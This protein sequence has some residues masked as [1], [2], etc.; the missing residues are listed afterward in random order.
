MSL[1]SGFKSFMQGASGS[2]SLKD[3]QYARSMQQKNIQLAEEQAQ[4]ERNLDAVYKM[5]GLATDLGVA[6]NAGAGIDV[7]KLTKLWTDQVAS[8]EIDP[9]LS[10]LAA[11]LGNED[12]A[13]QTNPGF[14]FKGTQIGPDG[15]LTLVGGYEGDDKNKFAT[16][17][18]KSGEE[19]E[20]GFDDP[21]KV[22]GLMA[23]QYNQVWNRPG[24]SGAKRSFQ[25]KRG[26][27]EEGEANRDTTEKL[28]GIGVAV[29]QLTTEVEN[30]IGATASREVAAATITKMKRSLANQPYSVQLEV[31]QEAAAALKIPT[32]EIIT[33]EVQQAAAEETQQTAAPN[34]QSQAE[35]QAEP[36]DNT[37]KIEE[38][39]RKKRNISPMRGGLQ[40]IEVIQK[41][42][43][44]LKAGGSSAAA[45]AS[46]S[47]TG[48]ATDQEIAEFRKQN[49]KLFPSATRER[50]AELVEGEKFGFKRSA[51]T[52]GEDPIIT[53]GAK[54]GVEA[55]DEDII[56]G[57]VA[58]TAEEIAALQ[59]R[60]E[61]K[62]IKSLEQ[63]NEASQAEQQLMRAMLSEIAVNK[64]QRADYL[65]RFNNVLSTGSTDYDAKTLATARQTAFSDETARRNSTRLRDEF[66]NKITGEAG[67]AIGEAVGKMRD[68]LFD[69]E[70]G[71]P[72]AIDMKA[73]DFA[74][75]GPGGSIKSIWS[76]FKNA[77]RLVKRNPRNK[78][79]ATKAS[80]QRQALL[81]QLSL[82]L[83]VYNKSDTPEVSW[84]AT[85]DGSPIS[86]S[87]STL[88]QIKIAE[89]DK[90][91]A[92]V[93]FHVLKADGKTQNGD[94]ISA[95]QLKS[96]I[97][98]DEL[99]EFFVK[100]MTKFQDNR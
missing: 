1:A 46:E 23:N 72:K 52:E 97:G 15:T 28:A 19:A 84:L 64:E 3:E 92:P 35:P 69:K 57:R 65:K 12:F 18:R 47:R 95:S 96:K 16:V 11:L 94:A 8:G 78:V 45:P 87:D 5:T 60:L 56:E 79:A 38:L 83:Q 51:A 82:Y 88:S 73:V 85:D 50:L 59:K 30:A 90:N 40:K 53:E 71:E 54:K 75:F 32:D 25:L 34:A 48:P 77:N 98:N 33:P 49:P 24:V 10:E 9:R 74:A 21:E 76:D 6:E 67:T 13:A 22:A 17:D 4:R 29:G 80:M 70:S 42:I 86:A 27:L 93:V 62:G 89:R 20:V 55:T 37:A 91:G 2:A 58:I 26:L 81:E 100:E 44:R 63:M 61:I 41:E 7:G 99:Y 43:D 39:E 36:V 31:L 68:A 66:D 14:S